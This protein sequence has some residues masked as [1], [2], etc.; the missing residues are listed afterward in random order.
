MK[1][2][3]NEE[4]N[5]KIFHMHGLAECYENYSSPKNVL[6]TTNHQNFADIPHRNRGG[7]TNKQTNPKICRE[8]QNAP[9]NQSNHEEKKK[10]TNIR[11]ISI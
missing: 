7:K 11:S 4:K 6:L 2:F 9:Y 3:K 5:V 10:K 8:A 1:I